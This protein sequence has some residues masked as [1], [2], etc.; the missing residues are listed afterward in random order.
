MKGTTTLE[1]L[2]LTQTEKDAFSSLADELQGM[3]KA[4]RNALKTIGEKI[5]NE[6]GRTSDGR[7]TMKQFKK[8]GANYDRARAADSGL[9]G[10]RQDDDAG[11]DGRRD[12]G[13]VMRAVIELYDT[14]ISPTT[15]KEKQERFCSIGGT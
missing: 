7:G 1:E 3:E 9:E 6:S 5:V 13:T 15:K 12:R 2:K 14:K 4:M 11:H 10:N 8:E